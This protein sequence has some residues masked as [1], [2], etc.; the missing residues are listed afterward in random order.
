MSGKSVN[1]YFVNSINVQYDG[2]NIGLLHFKNVK[3][4]KSQVDMP[5]GGNMA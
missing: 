5:K 1:Y 4:V 2:F 3:H